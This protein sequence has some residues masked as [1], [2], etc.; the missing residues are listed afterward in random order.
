MTM[1][2]LICLAAAALVS[3]CNGAADTPTSPTTT[4]EPRT[5][6]FSGTLQPGATRFYSY[7]LTSAGTVTAMLASVERSGGPVA[8]ALEL[9]IGVPAGTGCATTLTAI[10]GSA[11]VP[12]LQHEAAAGTYCVRIADVEGLPAASTFTIR[13]IY[14]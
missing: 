9:G 7:T 13:V 3:A 12:Q 1:Q 2:R 4:Y 14:P 11:L 10:G 5:I 8:N 6:L